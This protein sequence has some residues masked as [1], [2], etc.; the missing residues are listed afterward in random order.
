MQREIE[1]W[2]EG[3]P[4]EVVAVRGDRQMMTRAARA[5]LRPGVVRV[6]IR[7]GEDLSW[8]FCSAG[9]EK[10]G[11][12]RDAVAARVE[13]VRDILGHDGPR[14]RGVMA[15]R[16]AVEALTFTGALGGVGSR[17]A[18]F[19]GCVLARW[20]ERMGF[21]REGGARCELI[22]KREGGGRVTRCVREGRALAAGALEAVLDPATRRI[23]FYRRGRTSCFFEA[24]PRG[25]QGRPAEAEVLRCCSGTWTC[26][27]RRV[28]VNGLCY[29]VG[30]SV[31]G[32]VGRVVSTGGVGVPPL[33]LAAR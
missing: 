15:Q 16:V 1:I 9:W 18:V 28:E 27:F 8:R 33:L 19:P 21:G 13:V 31:T 6:V 22:V 20:G 7:R 30:G 23:H 11:Q 25:G 17:L 26:T 2:Y 10:D 4:A 32:F 5:A 24:Q 29:D 14:S 3:R 12:E